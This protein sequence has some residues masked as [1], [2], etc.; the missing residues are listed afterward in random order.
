MTPSQTTAANPGRRLRHRRLAAFAAAATILTTV[1]CGGD[2]STGPQTPTNPVGFYDLAK[3]DR[4]A[5]PTEV[6]RG[7]YTDQG[8]RYNVS[9]QVTRGGIV[10]D[11]SGA[12]LLA[13]TADIS[14][15]TRGSS[16]TISAAGGWEVQG[17]EIAL[18]SPQG[19]LTGSIKN[20]TITLPLDVVGN[21][22][23]KKYTFRLSQ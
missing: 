11:E 23:N 21:G 7:P 12:F 8:I 15:D 10:L 20:G 4:A 17:G 9:I 1:A 22:T 19:T 2:S 5:I 6:Y 3:V 13:V 16:V 18:R 14:T